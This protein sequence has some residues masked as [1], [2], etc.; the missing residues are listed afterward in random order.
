LRAD[1]EKLVSVYKQ[2]L[3]DA[4]FQKWLKDN[5]TKG[6]WIGPEKTTQVIQETF[7]LIKKFQSSVKN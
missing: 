1:Y 6:N 5:H 2:T 4:D 3:D 7:D